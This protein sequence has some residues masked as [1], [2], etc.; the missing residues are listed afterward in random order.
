[1]RYIICLNLATD[2]YKR[3]RACGFCFTFDT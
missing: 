3:A 1:M 2:R